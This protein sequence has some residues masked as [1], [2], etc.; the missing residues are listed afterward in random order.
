MTQDSASV[1]V[2]V[3][4]PAYNAR[5]IVGRAI[6]S[7]LAQTHPGWELIVVDDASSDGTADAVEARYAGEP[8]ARVIRATSNG[9]PARARNMALREARGTWVALID[10]DDAWKPE[11]LEHML[12]IAAKGADAVFDNLCGFDAHGGIQTGPVFPALAEDGFGIA[13]LVAPVVAGSELDYGYLKPM[14]RGAFLREHAITYDESLRSAEDLVFYIEVFLAGAA[15]L[16]T[17]EP[18]YI[19]TTP[20]GSKTG[21]FSDYS[22]S[23]PGD[24]AV[25]VALERLMARRRVGPAHEARAAIESRMS[26]LRRIGPVSSFYYARRKRDFASM[27]RLAATEPAVQVELSRKVGQVLARKVKRWAPPGRARAG[28]G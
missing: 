10:A 3:L 13:E 27:L 5:T 19:Y 15:V 23:V 4:L 11:R 28:E 12:A 2:S 20:R 14:M 21:L 9:G 26:F 22:H 6:D 17:S 16:A 25:V 7:V 24:A 18:L 8:R 1:S